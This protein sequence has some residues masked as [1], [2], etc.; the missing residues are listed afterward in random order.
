MTFPPLPRLVDQHLGDPSS[1]WSIGIPGA[2]GEFSYDTDE[3]AAIHLDEACK[4]VVTARGAI[5]AR[6]PAE[7]RCIAHE[8]IDSESQ[9]WS[10]SLVFCLPERAAGLPT[11]HV[12]TEIGPDVD[13]IRA[14]NRK[15][16]LFDLGLGSPYLQFCVRSGA[17]ELLTA[18]RRGAGTSIFEPANPA[19]KAILQGSPH[20][21]LLSR[22]GRIE[23]F[24]GIPPADGGHKSPLG[25]HTHL[26]PELLATDRTGPE[27]ISMPDGWV[28]ALTLYPPHPLRDPQGRP[29]PF[30]RRAHQALESFSPTSHRLACRIALRQLPYLHD[31][32]VG[33][34]AWSAALDRHEFEATC[35][36]PKP[37]EASEP[38]ARPR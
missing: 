4:S 7:I 3:P 1:G 37:P 13:A 27:T 32:L 26:L 2:I 5:A 16:L 15:D 11:H 38:Y 10:Q 34:D 14:D 8:S 33:L 18:L 24:Q 29:H 31:R 19:L 9:S 36:S 6:L 21:V 22:L 23:I 12:L 28:P 20:R 25:P 17:Q 30:D 35:T